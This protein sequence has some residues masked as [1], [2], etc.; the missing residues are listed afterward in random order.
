LG[1]AQGLQGSS[2]PRTATVWPFDLKAYFA[3]Y[4]QLCPG[5]P[6]NMRPLADSSWNSRT[7]GARF[8]GHVPKKPAAEFAKFLAV[9]KRGQ[10]I[11]QYDGNSKDRQKAELERACDPSRGDRARDEVGRRSRGAGER[12]GAGRGSVTAP[13]F[14]ENR[15]LKTEN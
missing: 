10:A 11:A 5:I 7:S 6:V 9:A 14:T 3:R 8:L 4:A 12:K 1:D 2:G 13:C 15:K